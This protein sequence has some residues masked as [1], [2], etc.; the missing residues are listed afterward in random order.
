METPKIKNNVVN[1]GAKWRLTAVKPSTS[2]GVNH[3]KHP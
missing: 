2:Q 3:Y 1:I